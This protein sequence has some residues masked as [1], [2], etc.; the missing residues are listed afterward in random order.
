MHHLLGL[1]KITK[2]HEAVAKC[3]L[4][5][6]W[7]AKLKPPTATIIIIELIASFKAQRSFR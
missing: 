5:S 7:D 2:R 6:L 1:L 3:K 4:A